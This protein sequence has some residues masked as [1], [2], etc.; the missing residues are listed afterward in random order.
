MNIKLQLIV[1]NEGQAI[2]EEIACLTRGKLSA[3]TLGL[4]LKESKTILSEIQ[5][6]M[7]TQQVAEHVNGVRSCK[8]CGKQRAIHGY[9]TLTYRT[10]FGE[11]HFKSPRL[12]E[13]YCHS[14]IKVTFSPIAKI[15]TQHTA[16]EYVYLQSE[17][18]SIMSYNEA[19]KRLAEILPV[20]IRASS[21]YHNTQNV[22]DRLESELGEEKFSFIEGCDR[23][24]DN[25]PRPDMPLIV[26]LDGGYV[27]AREGNNRKAG[28]FE[29][30]VG[31]IL[32]DQHKS[33]RF[34]FVLDYDAKKKRHV[35]EALKEQGLQLNQGISFLTDGGGTVRDLTTCLSPESEHILDWFHITKRITVMKQM[36]KNVVL[37][38]EVDLEKELTSIKHYLWHGNSFQALKKAEGLLFY[39]F[40]PE[41]KD[42]KQNKL[43]QALNEFYDYIRNNKRFIINYGE[44]YRHNERISTA[45]VES[46]VNE[47]ISKRMVKQQQ[48]RWTKKGAHLLLQVRIQVLNDTLKQRFHKWYPNMEQDNKPLPL[49]A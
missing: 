9:H 28:W 23:I 7:V 12:V 16:P 35:Y 29:V 14:H 30:I 46:T 48:M 41:R 36:A 40:D 34:G 8:D 19:A 25:L 1:E 13:C 17:W 11:L 4:S 42:D 32:Q 3:E 47:V 33:R 15:L 20:H 45:F 39:E 37:N 2:T 38:E 44:R 24:R 43:S 49:A 22:A 31:K 5:K 10:L 26:G 18:A 6:S 21:I 27:H